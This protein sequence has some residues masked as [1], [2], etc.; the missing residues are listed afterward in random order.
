MPTMLA[1]PHTALL[2]LLR[3]SRRLICLHGRDHTRLR[4]F[5]FKLL[6]VLRAW[7][8]EAVH[9]S[10]VMYIFCCYR[11]RVNNVVDVTWRYVLL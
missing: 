1:N 5:R 9:G 8:C 6:A 11:E 4:E 10:R 2:E 7:L 3:C